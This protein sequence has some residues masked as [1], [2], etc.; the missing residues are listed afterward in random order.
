M[1]KELRSIIDINYRT[2]GENI[3]FGHS[4]GGLF[5]LNT[6][7]HYTEAFDVYIAIDPSLWWDN[8]K[9]AKDAASLIQT[10]QFQDKTLY[11]GVA[12]MM[13][14]DRQYI[15]MDVMKQFLENTLPNGRK[16]TYYS[17]IF[18]DENHGSIPVPGM[19]DAFRKIYGKNK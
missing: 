8:A 12:G 17:K 4:F 13:R 11:I 6:F 18:P 3:L 14:P 15:H 5:A 9:L 19:I 1:I 7:L 2:N 16:L 10:G